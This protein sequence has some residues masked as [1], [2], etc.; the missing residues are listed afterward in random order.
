MQPLSRQSDSGKSHELW[1]DVLKGIAI[2]LVVYGHNCTDNSFV[3]AFHMPLFFLL[4]G[5]LFSPKP[6]RT[7]L[8]RSVTRLV[9]PYVVFLV[10]IALPQLASLALHG[11]LMGGV[12]I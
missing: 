5:F 3:Q 4:S 2:I 7:Y 9:V 1:I 6:A 8:H 12:N 11:N 10:I